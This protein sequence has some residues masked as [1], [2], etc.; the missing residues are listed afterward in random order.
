MNI[1]RGMV[2]YNDGFNGPAQT[3]SLLKTVPLVHYQLTVYILHTTAY[4][5]HQSAADLANGE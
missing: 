3:S 2:V 4:I 1:E 5:S